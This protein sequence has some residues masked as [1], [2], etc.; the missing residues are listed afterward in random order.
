ME[1]DEAMAPVVDTEAQLLRQER[2]YQQKR[3]SI[4]RLQEALAREEE[5]EEEIR[6][7]YINM[8][9]PDQARVFNDVLDNDNVNTYLSDVIAE[10]QRTTLPRTWADHNINTQ[11]I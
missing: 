7:E 2:W 8:L 11:N 10:R 3:A 4:R 9:N 5:E 1:A 6:N